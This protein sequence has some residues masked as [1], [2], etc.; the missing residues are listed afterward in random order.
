MRMQVCK[1]LSETTR[2][3]EDTE[4]SVEPKPI[5]VEKEETTLRNF[6]ERKQM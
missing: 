2:R 1:K 4:G 6:S 5:R 3:K